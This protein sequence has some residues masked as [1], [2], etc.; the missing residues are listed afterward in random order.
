MSIPQDIA[1]EAD[2]LGAALDTEMNQAIAEAAP[3]GNFSARALNA[4][5]RELNALLPLFGAPAYPEF[6]E[7]Q[8][9]FPPEFVEQLMMVAGAAGQAGVTFDMDLAMVEDDRDLAMLAGLLKTLGAEEAFIAFLQQPIEE[10]VVAEETVA[11]AP[12]DEITEEDLF[13]ERM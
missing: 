12:T 2:A 1:A 3:Q 10:E 7:D 13:V 11:V 5:V 4:V 8:T 9:V 6:T